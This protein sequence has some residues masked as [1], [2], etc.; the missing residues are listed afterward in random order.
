MALLTTPATTATRAFHRELVFRAI[1]VDVEPQACG[2]V[3]DAIEEGDYIFAEAL[4]TSHVEALLRKMPIPEAAILGFTIYPL[5]RA[6]FSKDFRAKY[7]NFLSVGT[8]RG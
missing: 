7:K 4:V 3:V 8:C 1:G 5:L 6:V 2:G